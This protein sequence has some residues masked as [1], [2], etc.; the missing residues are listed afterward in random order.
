MHWRILE[1]YCISAK[2]QSERGITRLSAI[3]GTVRISWINIC[4]RR[5]L[6]D[7][8]NSFSPAIMQ[9]ACIDDKRT[10]FAYID[11]GVPSGS[12]DYSTVVIVHG[13][14]YHARNLSTFTCFTG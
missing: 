1:Y 13:H 9:K 3:L 8:R 12:T 5:M 11:S 10:E 7:S 2:G 14:T 4:I 6:S